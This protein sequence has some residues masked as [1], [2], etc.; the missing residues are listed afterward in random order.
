MGCNDECSLGTSLG[1]GSQYIPQI[2]RWKKI[3]GT[4]L[5]SPDGCGLDC[6]VWSSLLLSG[7]Y[8]VL[9]TGRSFEMGSPDTEDWRSENET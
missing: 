5:D 3:Y 8:F 1:N 4:A 9:I 2:F 7:R 6:W